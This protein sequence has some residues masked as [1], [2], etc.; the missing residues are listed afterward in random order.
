MTDRSYTQFQSE[1]VGTQTDSSGGREYVPHRL[2]IRNASDSERIITV[3]ISN[4]DGE[5]F[6]ERYEFPA[7]GSLL[8]TLL[9]ADEYTVEL[10]GDDVSD[11]I[12][13]EEQWF[14]CNATEHIITVEKS[15]ETSV[16]ESGTLRPCGETTETDRQ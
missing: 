7:A 8:I 3:V 11:T 15:G 5:V 9:N 12:A 16:T 2:K 6:R 10:R 1:E 4:S 13:I 14:D